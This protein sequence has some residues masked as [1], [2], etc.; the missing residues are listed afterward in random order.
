[1]KGKAKNRQE[2]KAGVR[3]E[4][5]EG[6]HKMLDPD[7]SPSFSS[8]I[9]LA[10]EPSNPQPQHDLADA[11]YKGKAATKSFRIT[12]NARGHLREET[13]RGAS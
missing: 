13:L 3:Q 8:D 9:W 12:C 2:E 1:M 4:K 10:K 11:G 7:L 5:N 6:H